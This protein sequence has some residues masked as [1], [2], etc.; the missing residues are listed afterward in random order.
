M[1]RVLENLLNIKKAGKPIVLA[2]GFFDGVHRGHQKVL[3]TAR[4]N[5][6]A[7]DGHAWVLTFAVHPMKVL[8]PSKKPPLIT[9]NEHKLKIMDEMQLDGCI[10][11]PFE[12][13]TSLM[14]AEEFLSML[15]NNIGNLEEIVV[16]RNWKFGKGGT[17]TT[18][19]L[20]KLCREKGLALTVVDPVIRDG[21]PVSSTRI[22]TQILTGDL[23]GAARMLG[24]P[25]SVLG[26]VVRGKRMARGL[27]FPTAN[28]KT[29]DEVLPPFGV[30]AVMVYLE[31]KTHC[32]VLNFGTRPTFARGAISKPVME[33][34]I[35]DY[36]GD[37]YGRKI[38]VVVVEKLR[39][40]KKFASKDELKKQIDLDVRLAGAVLGCC[41]SR[42]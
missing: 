27:G 21:Q 1:M 23:K 28:L 35:M 12:K 40:E 37:L 2:A 19:V 4:R 7:R 13:S 11:M 31:Q 8:S 30:Y 3:E 16:G 5:A 6:S 25:V 33:I 38:E 42:T 20:S 15:Q 36:N 41:G 9:S 34:H 18:R 32:G 22:R 10:L 17:G 24:R 39:D 14:S 29:E 26:E